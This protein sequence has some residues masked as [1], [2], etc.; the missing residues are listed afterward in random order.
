MWTYYADGTMTVNL[1]DGVVVRIGVNY[2]L[3][4]IPTSRRKD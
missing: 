3:P 4:Q 2:G 1:A